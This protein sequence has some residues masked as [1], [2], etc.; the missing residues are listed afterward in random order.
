MKQVSS[1]KKCHQRTFISKEEKI[2]SGPKVSKERFT[3]LLGGNV[4]G[5][6][7]LKP[8]LVYKSETPRA[9]KNISKENLPVVWMSNK[10]G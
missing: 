10:K 2:A 7:K 6:F 3:L 8:L 9:M 5:D 1:G 4:A